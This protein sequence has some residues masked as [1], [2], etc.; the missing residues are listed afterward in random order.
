[1]LNKNQMLLRKLL[2]C[3]GFFF[4]KAILKQEVRLDI[5][6]IKKAE[7]CLIVGTAS[8]FLIIG[9][10]VTGNA[11]HVAKLLLAERGGDSRLF[12]PICKTHKDT[13]MF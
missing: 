12:Q 6:R 3:R 13:S 7:Q 5:K 11:Y 9:N 4:C 8:A 10:G 1:M 2:R